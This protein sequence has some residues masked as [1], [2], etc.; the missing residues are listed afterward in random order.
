MRKALNISIWVMLCGLLLTT[1]G[2]VESRSENFF[3]NGL[4]INID[5]SEG[6][7]FVLEEDV[8]NLVSNMGYN[9]EQDLV[10]NLD[11]SQIERLLKN[12]PSIKEAEVYTT[13]D[14]YLKVDLKQRKP[15]LRVFTNNNESYYIDEDGWLMP[16]S[17]KFSSKVVVANG[18]IFDQFST[19]Y[20][21]N[22]MALPE[23]NML[24][25]LYVISEFLSN[26]EFWKSQI[27]Q[28]YVDENSDVEL[29]PRVGN[30]NII[31][32]DANNLENKMEKLMIFYKKGLSKTGWNEYTTINLKYKDQIVCTK[33]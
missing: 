22:V 23:G 25:Q 16:L 12:N 31:L 19:N 17:N 1:L 27:V 13:I 8:E 26:D 6:N 33:R 2:F 15:L 4:R 7:Y 29:I 21:T 14:G 32:G 3:C 24:R 30:H 18:E 10:T 5:R 11:I 9:V 20:Q 28:I